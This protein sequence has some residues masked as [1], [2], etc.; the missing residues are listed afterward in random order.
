[1]TKKVT[2]DHQEIQVWAE[3]FRGRPEV[4]DDPRAGS[5]RVGIRID[6]PGDYDDHAISR[7]VRKPVSWNEFFEK[8]DQLEYA[9]IYHEPLRSGTHPSDA[10]Q[11]LKRERIGE[12]RVAE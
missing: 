11:F 8:F 7:R 12:E 3:K 6:F 5:D 4:I 10:Y 1:M 9:F 2:T